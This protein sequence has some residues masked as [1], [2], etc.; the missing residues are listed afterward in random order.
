MFHVRAIDRSNKH[1]YLDQ[2]EQHFRIRHD[3]Y[4]GERDWQD[5]KRPD[6][7]EIDAFDNDDAIYLLGI[8]ADD[9]VVAGSRLVPSLKPHLMSDVFPQLAPNGIPRDTD[10]FE[11]T[12][13]FVIPALRRPGRSCLAAGIMYCGL[14]EYCLQQSIH[15]LSGVCETYWIAR[16]TQLGWRP[17]PLGPPIHYQGETIIGITVEMSVNAFEMTRRAYDIKHTVLWEKHPPMSATRRSEQT[18]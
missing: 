6:G 1:L 2:L 9:R 18:S 11:W 16:L 12:R 4:V 10:L 5:L 15:R 17:E 14:L 3:I 7:R 8:T 13:I